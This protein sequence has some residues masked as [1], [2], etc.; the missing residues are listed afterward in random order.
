VVENTLDDS[1]IMIP[2]RFL[3]CTAGGHYSPILS[4]VA[5]PGNAPIFSPV[6]CAIMQSP[7]QKEAGM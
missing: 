5:N 7:L 1:V 4:P 3:F 2:L 6:R